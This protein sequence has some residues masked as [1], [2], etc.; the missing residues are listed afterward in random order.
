MNV[1]EANPTNVKDSASNVVIFTNFHCNTAVTK[2]NQS[3]V[4][5]YL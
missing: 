4:Y 5:S 2:V 1:D 3:V